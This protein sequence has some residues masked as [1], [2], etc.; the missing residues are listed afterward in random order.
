VL[1]LYRPTCIFDSCSEIHIITSGHANLF[2]F[3]VFS[4]GTLP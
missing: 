2:L 3:T 4:T 1:F